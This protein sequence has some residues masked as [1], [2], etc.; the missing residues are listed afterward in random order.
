MTSESCRTVLREDG[1]VGEVP[2][3]PLTGGAQT[4]G[5]VRVGM[6]VRRPSFPRAHF[7]DELLRHLEAVGFEGAPRVLGYDDQGRQVLSFVDG[8]VPHVLPFNLSDE[9]LLSA[10]ELVLA[11]HDATVM[12][13][14]RDGQEVVCHGDLGPH[15]TVFRGQRAVAIIDWDSNVRPGRRADDLA[16]AVWC[17]ADLT[18]A[19]VPVAEQARRTRLMCTAYPSMTPGVVVA[20]LI[21]RFQ[22]ARDQH[23]MA[24][25]IPATEVFDRLLGWMATHGEELATSH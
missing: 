11:F 22:R 9:Q 3:Q 7:V 20:E 13:P 16:H 1:R 8:T 18:E 17:F 24:G 2:E 14:L 19:A 10:S 21:D 4:R 15:N 5:L 12:S 6:T 23:A 25:R